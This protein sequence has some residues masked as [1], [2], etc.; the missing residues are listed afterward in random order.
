[1][2]NFD[3]NLQLIVV[4][5]SSAYGKGAV[6]YHLIDGLERAVCFMSRIHTSAEHNYYVQ[7]EKEALAFAVQVS[8]LLVGAA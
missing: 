8:L 2:K 4:A 6:L 3:P 5:D 1:M 7:I